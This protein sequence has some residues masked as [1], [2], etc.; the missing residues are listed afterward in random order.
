MSELP[1]A[2]KRRAELEA[3]IAQWAP[4]VR[5]REEQLS[6]MQAQVAAYRSKVEGLVDL[7]E[8]MRFELR[9]LKQW[10]GTGLVMGRPSDEKFVLPKGARIFT[11]YVPNFKS[12]ESVDGLAPPS[13]HFL[14]AGD[15]D[16]I[17][18][19][20]D[21]E[22]LVLPNDQLEVFWGMVNQHAI[23]DF[24]RQTLRENSEDYEETPSDKNEWD[25]TIKVLVFMDEPRWRLLQLQSQPDGD[26]GDGEM[27][28]EG[29]ST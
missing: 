10:L 2:E 15:S 16:Q 7:V 9:S 23:V 13:R 4:E 28:L 27:L 29:D 18:L 21:E 14:Y 3:Q 17:W 22:D 12:A 20:E 8:R 25:T 11:I 1:E 6:Q 26:L 19:V 5:M 24:A